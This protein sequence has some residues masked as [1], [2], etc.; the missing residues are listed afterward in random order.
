LR[1]SYTA[2]AVAVIASLTLGCGKNDDGTNKGGGDTTKV[3][4]PEGGNGA[5]APTNDGEVAPGPVGEPVVFS[6][7]KPSG[8]VGTIKGTIKLV[9]E[10][11]ERKP[12]RRGSDPYCAKT[13]VLDETVI[14]GEGG[15]L[16]N[17]LVRIKPGGVPAFVPP[18]TARV[19]QQECMYRPRVQGAVVGGKLSI[20]NVDQTFHNVHVRTQKWNDPASDEQLFNRGQPA[21]SPAI[22]T[23]LEDWEIVRLKCDSHGW[24]AGYV[25]LSDHPFFAT[26][27]DSGEFA[28]DQV[29]V[30]EIELQIWHELYGVKTAKVTVE[31]GKDAT[32]EV[33]FDATADNPNK[34][35]KDAK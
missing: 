29:P 2:L 25:I 8:A 24:M 34:A 22:K 5:T 35:G 30:G 31:D 18:E 12:L 16:K 6:K 17:V 14:V 21:G 7:P 11:P 33:T 27:G 10:P 26:T 9:G 1:P 32:V 13:E 19:E 23:G 3:V 15:G 20:N 28:I 4:P